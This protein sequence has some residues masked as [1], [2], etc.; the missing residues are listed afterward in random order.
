MAHVH[1]RAFLGAS[2]AIAVGVGSGRAQAPVTNNMG[3]GAMTRAERNAVADVADL[4]ACQDRMI[5]TVGAAAG[6]LFGEYRTGDVAEFLPR[7]I[8]AGA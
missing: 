2:A 1:R 4:V 7:G 6:R 5:G 8:L 3:W